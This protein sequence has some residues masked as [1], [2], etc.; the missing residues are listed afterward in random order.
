MSAGPRRL[1]AAAEAGIP[2]IV[3]VG[4]TDMT[5]FGPKSTVPERY[6]DRRL[7]EHNPVVTLMRTSEEEARQVGNFIAEK[8]KKHVK[9]TDLVQV[10]LP[11]GGISLISTPEGPFADPEADTALFRSLKEGLD[12][13]GIEIIEDKRS[14]N[15]PGFAT[16]IAEA[17]MAKT[18]WRRKS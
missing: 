6:K 4:A 1:D 16:D 7:Y 18:Q 13:S 10:W 8:L 14:I 3:S 15:D 9:R 12:G 17:L 2:N 11:D 5:N